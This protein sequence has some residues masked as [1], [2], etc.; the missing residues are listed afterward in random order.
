MPNPNAQ[1]NRIKNPKT[2]GSRAFLGTPVVPTIDA[3]TSVDHY[4]VPAP[5]LVSRGSGVFDEFS[6]FSSDSG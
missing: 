5:G 1:V 2:V 4:A 6:F 3:R